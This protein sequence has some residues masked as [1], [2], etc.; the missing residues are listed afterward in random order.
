[1]VSKALLRTM[2]K[3]KDTVSVLVLLTVRKIRHHR[4]RYPIKKKIIIVVGSMQKKKR[5]EKD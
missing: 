4:M 1:M 2:E 5:Q 3:E